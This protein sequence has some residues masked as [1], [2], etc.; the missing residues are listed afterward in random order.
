[1]S[2]GLALACVWAVVA[3]LCGMLPRRWH[4]P[5]AYALIAA[6]IPVLGLVTWQSGPV[7]GFVV[8]AAGMSVLRWPLLRAGGWLRRRARGET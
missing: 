7:W 3:A 1:M 6:G 2:T 4:W 5:A 8:L